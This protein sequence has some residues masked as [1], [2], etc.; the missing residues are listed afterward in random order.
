MALAFSLVGRFH[1]S[2]MVSALTEQQRELL[3]AAIT[4]HKDIRAELIR[5]IPFWPLGLPAWN[6]DWVVV[7][8]RL[9]SRIRLVLARR[10]GE[11]ERLTIPL[12]EMTAPR[13]TAPLG[14]GSQDAW[15]WQQT[16]GSL[17]VTV[18]DAPGAVVLDLFWEGENVS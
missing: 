1:L 12:P 13:V 9:P 18:G 7:G 3:S 2:G 17:V 4:A 8:L 10:A 16:T 5:S 11:E 6:D 15:S 14:A